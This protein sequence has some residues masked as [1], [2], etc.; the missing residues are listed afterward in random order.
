MR[1]YLATTALLFIALVVAHIARAY[2]EPSVARDPWFLLTTLI[3]LSFAAWGILLYR[4][5]S[6]GFPPGDSGKQR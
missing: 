5:R 2:F 3:A 6:Q 1:A 4:R